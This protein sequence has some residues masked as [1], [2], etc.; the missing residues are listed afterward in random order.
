MKYDFTSIIERHGKDALAIDSL[1]NGSAPDAPKGEFDAIP[2]WVADMNFATAPCILEA[3]RER[4]DHPL[5]GYFEPRAEYFESIIRWQKNRNG[6]DGLE[7]KHIGYDNGVLG[8]L[9]SAAM[10]APMAHA[11]EAAAGGQPQLTPEQQ[12]MLL[13]LLQQYAAVGHMRALLMC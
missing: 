8:G 13:Q 7:A 12:Q 1:G 9:L 10:L 4:L 5:F 6:V 2:M 11:D 3:V